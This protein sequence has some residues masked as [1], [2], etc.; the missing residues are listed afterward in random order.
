M[1][2]QYKIFVSV[3]TRFPMDRLVE[4]VD[5]FVAKNPNYSCIAQI[6]ASKQSYMHIETHNF[7]KEPE[8]KSLA[9]YNEHVNDHQID[10][11]QAFSNKEFLHVVYEA[12]ELSR[13]IKG[14]KFNDKQI[15]NDEPLIRLNEAINSFINA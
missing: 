13:A 6:G 5:K 9:I 15:V 7:L 3:G 1:D 2:K 11:A 12:S 10:S 14:L 4:G 8:F